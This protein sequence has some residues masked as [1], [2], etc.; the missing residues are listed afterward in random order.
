MMESREERERAA[1]PKAEAATSSEEGSPVV[2]AAMP[3]WLP[4]AR[5]PVSPLSSQER[6]R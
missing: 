1:L 2:R 5:R 4:W 6:K 3:E